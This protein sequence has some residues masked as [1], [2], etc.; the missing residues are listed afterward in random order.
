MENPSLLLHFSIRMKFQL[1]AAIITGANLKR[2]NPD[3]AKV[4]NT[5]MPDSSVN[6]Q[7]C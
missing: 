3:D 1:T 4:C 2:A 7:G 6:N 5:T